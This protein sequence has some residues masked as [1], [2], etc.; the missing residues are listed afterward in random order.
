MAEKRAREKGFKYMIRETT[1]PRL[2]KTFIANGY[3]TLTKQSLEGIGYGTGIKMKVPA[4]VA[5]NA[6]MVFPFR[7][8]LKNHYSKG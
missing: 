4:K 5:L 1:N 6:R 8:N 3:Q 2:A 7:W